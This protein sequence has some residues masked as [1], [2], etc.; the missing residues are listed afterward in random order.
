MGCWGVDPF[1]L[2]LDR[3]SWVADPGGGERAEQ[4]DV[5]AKGMGSLADLQP[6]PDRVYMNRSVVETVTLWRHDLRWSVKEE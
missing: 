1:T 3:C 2:T 4:K 6:Y 5:L